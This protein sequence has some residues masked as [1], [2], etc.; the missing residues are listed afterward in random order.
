[1]LAW[2]TGWFDSQAKLLASMLYH[3]YAWNMDT[4]LR[5]SN[6]R[7]TRANPDVLCPFFLFSCSRGVA[8]D[9]PA[10]DLAQGR[11]SIPTSIWLSSVK[12]DNTHI[13]GSLHEWSKPSILQRENSQ[14]PA[15]PLTIPAQTQA[16]KVSF[17]DK[18]TF[19]LANL[20]QLLCPRITQ[21]FSGMNNKPKKL[22]S[23]HAGNMLTW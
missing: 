19:E 7:C 8:P 4:M 5:I 6:E 22:V 17:L 12:E 20:Q 1:M 14:K 15:V 10:P 2:R 18:H 13:F 11:P 3:L 21:S 9:S 23:F 16:D